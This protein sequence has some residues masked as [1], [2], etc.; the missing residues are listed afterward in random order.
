MIAIH[1]IPI[2]KTVF[3]HICKTQSVLH[4]GV[5]KGGESQTKWIILALGSC[6][7]ML[8][9][10]PQVRRTHSHDYVSSYGDSI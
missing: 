3:L 7:L 2:F 1:K 10:D 9:T 4:E 8:L 6:L 5:E